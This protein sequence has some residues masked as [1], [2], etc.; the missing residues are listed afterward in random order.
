MS[1]RRCCCCFPTCT[2][3]NQCAYYDLAW[4]G[5]DPVACPGLA[6]DLADLAWLNGLN[7]YTGLGGGFDAVM[8]HRFR[9]AFSIDSFID[10]LVSERVIEV[11]EWTLNHTVKCRYA[12]YPLKRRAARRPARGR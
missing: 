11:N 6:E 9:D 8:T 1:H 4:N 12:P 2:S 7:G 3:G 5:A 10:G